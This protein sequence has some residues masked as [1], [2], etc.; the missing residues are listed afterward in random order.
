MSLPLNSPLSTLRTRLLFGQRVIDL[1]SNSLILDAKAEVEG[2]C[3]VAL[4]S[5]LVLKRP[6]WSLFC[7]GN[8]FCRGNFAL[9]VGFG[10]FWFLVV[11]GRVTP[12]FSFGRVIF[13]REKRL[14]HLFFFFVL[15]IELIHI[16]LSLF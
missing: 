10:Y 6:F 16:V 5:Y 8:I 14:E 12:Y 15:S 1:L 11:V 3:Q 4:V 13:W 2:K 7:F 9:R